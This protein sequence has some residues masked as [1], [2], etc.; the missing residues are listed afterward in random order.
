MNKPEYKARTNKKFWLNEVNKITLNWKDYLVDDNGNIKQFVDEWQSVKTGDYKYSK[1]DLW[2]G[3]V[4]WTWQTVNFNWTDYRITQLWGSITGWIDLA[5]MKAGTKGAIWAFEWWE[6]VRY[7]TDKN[8]GNKYIEV[9]NDNGYVYRYNHLDSI[10]NVKVWDKIT[11]WTVIG[12]MWNTGRVKWPTGVHLDLAVYDGKRA[13][14]MSVSPLNIKDQA[15]VLFGWGQSQITTKPELATFYNRFM[16]SESKNKLT[17]EEWKTI[18]SMWVSRSDFAKQALEHKKVQDQELSWHAK[19]LVWLIDKLDNISRT[20]LQNMRAN[21]PWTDW[22][23]LRNIYNRVLASTALQ[24][25]IDLKSEWATFGALSDNELKFITNA[26]NNLD[27]W[28]KRW[29]LQE[30][31]KEYKRILEKWIGGVSQTETKQTQ[32]QQT[33]SSNDR[34]SS[35]NKNNITTTPTQSNYNL[36]NYIY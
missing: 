23:D 24:K 19:E 33:F 13:T 35:L 10:G 34:W 27:L 14:S 1:I 26:S 36:S 31:L 17:S 12:N 30:N 6:V 21:T 29:T 22:R 4:V 11:Q 8:T 20:D 9:L 16:S 5:P 3:S 25:L 28:T 2:N 7:W 15:S 32:E 18:E